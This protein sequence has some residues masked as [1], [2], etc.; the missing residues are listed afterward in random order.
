MMKK[1]VI[2]TVLTGGYEHLAQPGLIRDGYDY[3]CFTDAG[4]GRDGVW[5]LRSIPFETPDPITRARYSKLQPHVVLPDY[6]YSIFLDANI[7]ISGDGFYEAVEKAIAEGIT[8]AGVPHPGRDCVYDEL[9]YCYL[10]DKVSTRAAFRHLRRLKGMG[11]PRHFGLL[12]TGILLRAHNT[13]A[14]ISI[15]DA[16]WAGFRKCCTRDQL[17]LTP[18]LYT[19]GV[20]PALLFGPG[21]CA[22][23]VPFVRY[24]PHP[25]SG[26]ENTPGRL[27]WGNVRYRVRLM[28]RK[29]CLMFLK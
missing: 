7:C 6:D 5:E 17:T 28:W 24:T 26:K 16:W 25:R 11:M 2:Y 12:E 21:K 1:A 13:P 3:I 14:I 18:V 29:F 15:D 4:E 27:T 8:F 23:N 19:L 22:R 20:Q 10:K 9:R